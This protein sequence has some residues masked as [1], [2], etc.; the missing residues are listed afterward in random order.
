MDQQIKMHKMTMALSTVC[1]IA[2]VA[3]E[4]VFDIGPLQNWVPFLTPAFGLLLA[5]PMVWAMFKLAKASAK[6]TP[7]FKHGMIAMMGCCSMLLMLMGSGRGNQIAWIFPFTMMFSAMGLLPVLKPVSRVKQLVP[8]LLSTVIVLPV[9]LFAIVFIMFSALTGFSIPVERIS[10]IGDPNGQ[11]EVVIY[12]VDSGALGMD[13][14]YMAEKHY[15]DVFAIK[16]RFDLF[17]DPMPIEWLN[18]H[19]VKIGRDTYTV[20]WLP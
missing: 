18:D 15:F 6:V 20:P 14:V 7:L 19:Q 10:A 16:R 1:F 8:V 5:L 4:V 2:W 11:R 9:T 12:S 17:S 13:F 3:V